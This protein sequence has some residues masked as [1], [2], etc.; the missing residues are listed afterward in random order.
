MEN[1]SGMEP[2]PLRVLKISV[3]IFRANIHCS[4]LFNIVP[5]VAL[6]VVS[7]LKPNVSATLLRV[8][9]DKS[10]VKSNGIIILLYNLVFV[11]PSV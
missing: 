10:K 1:K 11:I 6:T 5:V 7:L 9:A 4:A 2:D 3:F 8:V